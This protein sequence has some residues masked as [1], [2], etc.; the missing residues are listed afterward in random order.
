MA[1]VTTTP[2]VQGQAGGQDSPT[3]DDQKLSNVVNSAVASQLKRHLS[4][5]PE[6]IESQLA[7]LREQFAPKA[8]ETPKTTQGGDSEALKAIDDLKAQLKTERDTAAKE[9][10]I[11]REEKAF[12]ELRSELN[13][14]VR[15]EAV[16]IL[17]RLLF[18]A[19]RRV[20]V[21]DDGPI[22]FKLGE[23]EY[24]LQDGLAEY[25]RSSKEAAFFLPPPAPGQ[26]K[27][28][29]R[30]PGRMGVEQAAPAEDPMSKTLR[31]LQERKI[32]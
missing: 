9:R 2:D 12:N 5:L 27:P 3:I 20:V 24:S 22:A 15:P 13:G 30:A 25:F 7:P 31:M 1:D 18:Q 16:D 29:A 6:L 11:A 8:P 14:K 28:G 4:K 23:V 19:D 32:L 21:P 26:K 17:A 10:R